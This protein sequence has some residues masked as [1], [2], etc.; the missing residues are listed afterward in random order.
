[1]RLSFLFSTNFSVVVGFPPNRES[2]TLKRER[3]TS[4]KHI[5]ARPTEKI[6]GNVSGVA[7]LKSYLYN[8]MSR[9]VSLF[10][11]NLCDKVIMYIIEGEGD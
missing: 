1:M 6:R 3:T 9:K 7:T 4:A 5:N 10:W 2:V 8:P 11:T